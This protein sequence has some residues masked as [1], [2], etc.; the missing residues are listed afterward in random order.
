M[1]RIILTV[2]GTFFLFCAF[3]QEK[4]DPEIEIYGQIMTDIGFNFNQVNP[5]YFDVMRP[6]QLPSYKGEYGSDG[7]AYFGVRQSMLGFKTYLPTKHGPLKARIAFDLYG[8][9]A[10]AGQTTFH[11]LYAYIEYGKF[12]VGHTWSQFCDFDDFPDIVEYWGP[13]GM[14]LCKTVLFKYIPFDGANRLAIAIERPGSSAD[15]GVYRD[16]IELEDVA[17][18]FP[19]PDL[20]AEFRM[21]RKWGYIELAGII[22]KIEWIDMGN[23]PYDVSGSATGWGFNLSTKLNLGQKDIFKGQVITGEAIENLMNDAPTDIG[24]QNNYDNP[25]I[26]VKGVALPVTGFST[27]LDHRWSKSFSSS[28][29]YSAIFIT[30]T[31]GQTNDAFSQGHYSSINLLY[32]PVP[33]LTAGIELQWI[34]R[35]NYQD[36]W[37]SDATR[38]QCSFRYFFARK[39][40][41]SN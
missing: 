24:I 9:G 25:N 5:L 41:K 38:I 1:K 26:P 39:L 28:T 36:G 6:T 32:Y 31:D 2:Y 16:R 34:K 18:K 19:L 13:S 27:Y 12:G 23:Q 17:P 22:R 30:N 15:Q 7:N 8:V 11:M 3:A 35:K 40:A 10:N 4:N 20:S 37:E 14:S 33:N 29:G 21:T